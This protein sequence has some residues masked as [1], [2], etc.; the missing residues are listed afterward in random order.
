MDAEALTLD[1][2]AAGGLL[3]EVFAGEVTAALSA[4]AWCGNQAAVGEHQW[5]QHPLA[6]GGVLRCRS[7]SGALMVAVR[8][9]DTLRLGFP[10]VRWLQVGVGE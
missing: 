7:C 8:I 1:G 9:R 5:Y 4:C 3:N 2:N 6:P 10:G